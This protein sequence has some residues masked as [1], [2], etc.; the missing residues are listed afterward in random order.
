MAD[1]YGRYKYF[2][3]LDAWMGCVEMCVLPHLHSFPMGINFSCPNG[4][5][6]FWGFLA[7]T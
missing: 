1:G 3:N 5:W 7:D 2:R 4:N 6:G